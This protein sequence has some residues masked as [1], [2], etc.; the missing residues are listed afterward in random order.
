MAGAGPE[1]R[2]ER[3]RRL[4][5]QAL[6]MA[7]PSPY[8][9]SSLAEVVPMPAQVE[10]RRQESSDE[11]FRRPLLRVSIKTGEVLED[12]LHQREE[13]KSVGEIAAF[14]TGEGKSRRYDW[15]ALKPRIIELHHR[16]YAPARI[17]KT[18][19]IAWSDRAKARVES[20]LSS[21]GLEPHRRRRWDSKSPVGDVGD[22]RIGGLCPVEES[23]GEGGRDPAAASPAVTA[24]AWH[25]LF[26][27]VTCETCLHGHVCGRVELVKANP[28]IACRDWRR[29]EAS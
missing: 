21:A 1:D 8:G 16:G 14:A 11:Q 10:T 20:V 22:A 9:P 24:I 26:E 3:L 5:R 29:K 25:Q 23:L 2:R 28:W 4:L 19:G 15:E 27:G 7:Q 12:H 6:G 13:G 18:L 17:L